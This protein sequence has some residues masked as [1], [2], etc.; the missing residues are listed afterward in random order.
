MWGFNL[1]DYCE[2]VPKCLCFLWAGRFFVP[3]GFLE[4]FVG[5]LSFEQPSKEVHYSNAGIVAQ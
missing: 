4:D 5:F 3:Y 2:D 1:N